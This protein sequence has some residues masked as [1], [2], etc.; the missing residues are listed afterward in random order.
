LTGILGFFPA[1]FNN[2]DASIASGNPDMSNLEFVFENTFSVMR[3][4]LVVSAPVGIASPVFDAFRS[5]AAHV[6]G[7][8]FVWG[9]RRL[10][11]EACR[12]LKKD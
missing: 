5:V 11:L 8:R 6:R 12:K 3:N 4:N 7:Q 2:L 9:L 10:W 1:I